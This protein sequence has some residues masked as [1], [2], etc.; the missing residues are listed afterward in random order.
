MWG[1]VRRGGVR[2]G[3]QKSKL[4]GVSCVV[5]VSKDVLSSLGDPKP[6]VE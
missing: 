5:I 2:L 3:I 4:H 1:E 6:C